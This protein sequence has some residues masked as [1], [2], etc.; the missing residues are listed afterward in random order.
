VAEHGA[1]TRVLL[2][3]GDARTLRSLR[4]F[5]D[6]LG[7]F[8]AVA[9]ATG[10][11]GLNALTRQPWAAVVLVDDLND[12]RPEEVMA[13]ARRAGVRAALVGLSV[14]GDRARVQALYAGG[15]AEVVPLGSAPTPEIA[16]ALGRAIERQALVNRVDAL[17]AELA[18]HRAVDE[19]TG[20]YPRWRFDEDW[21]LEQAR[22]RRRHGP[23]SMLSVALEIVP[24]IAV[25][26][27]RD[28]LTVL[29][30]AGRIIRAAM[31]EGDL[32]AH[33]GGGRFRVLLPDTDGA[34][35]TDIAARLSIALRAALA[36]SPIPGV[37]IVHLAGAF[38]D[39][40][41]AALAR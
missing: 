13:R 10:G 2:I 33:D 8:E 22:A 6:S 1:R 26:T 36:N 16:R 35:A 31:R 39:A 3:G 19:A 20:L 40:P 9:V 18:Q 12:M 11:A 21:R 29:R 5:L 17:E 28:R 4:L 24:D 15:A 14:S 37:A 30:Q 23:L 27:E 34:L 38:E 25:L 7:V 41:S 32:A